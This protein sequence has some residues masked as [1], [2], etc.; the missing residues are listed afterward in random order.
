MNQRTLVLIPGLLCDGTVWRH[1]VDALADVA[2][3]VVVDHGE[4]DSIE[5]MARAVLSLPLPD[6]F[7]LAGHSMGGRV[8]LEILRLEPVRVERLALLDTGYQSRPKGAV[9][10]SERE[11]RLALLDIARRHG[12]RDMGT[13]WA[14]GMVHSDH[15]AT[16]V[17]ETMLQMIERNTVQRFANQIEALLHRPEAGSLLAEIACPILLLCGRHDMWS[18][19]SRHRDMLE[20]IPGA[21]LVVVEDAGHMTTMEQPAATSQAMRAWLT[22]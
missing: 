2:D 11:Q 1:Q 7:A 15:V 6:S 12:M 16:P 9:G 22:A 8:S 17:F 19:V 21:Q 5:A 14:R 20:L 10:E 18:P 3:C 4:C 13:Q